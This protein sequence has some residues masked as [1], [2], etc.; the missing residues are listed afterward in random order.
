MLFAQSNEIQLTKFKSK[1]FSFKL[2]KQVYI[3]SFILQFIDT[4]M[5]NLSLIV[6]VPS[7][8]LIIRKSLLSSQ[9]NVKNFE[10]F[11]S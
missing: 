6:P 8:L 7:K 5:I 10:D 3:N 9:F 4:I 11:N 2:L 1:S